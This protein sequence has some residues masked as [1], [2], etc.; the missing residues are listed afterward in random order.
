MGRGVYKRGESWN[1]FL[2][3][4]VGFTPTLTLPQ[5]PPVSPRRELLSW[6]G[7]LAVLRCSQ[8]L[9]KIIPKNVMIFGCILEAK[10]IPAGTQKTPK[11]DPKTNQIHLKLQVSFRLHFFTILNDPDPPFWRS[12]VHEKQFF[13]F[14]PC[15]EKHLKTPKK[16]PQKEPLGVPKGFKNKVKKQENHTMFFIDFLPFWD[17]PGPPFWNHLGSKM[18]QKSN[19]GAT[20]DPKPPQVTPQVTPGPSQG[21]FWTP[22]CMIFQLFTSICGPNLN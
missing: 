22:F 21:W 16:G 8:R 10:M 13:Q 6:K 2:G 1:S 14:W 15:L 9:P 18:T 4:R 7:F 12:R 20:W 17:P 5:A 3:K 11:V 19:P